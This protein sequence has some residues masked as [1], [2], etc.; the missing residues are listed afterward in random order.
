MLR[1]G[2]PCSAIMHGVKM[3]GIGLSVHVFGILSAYKEQAA[4]LV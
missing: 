1:L 2:Y 3:S 4:E